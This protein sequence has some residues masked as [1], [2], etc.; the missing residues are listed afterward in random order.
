MTKDLGRFNRRELIGGYL[1]WGMFLIGTELVVS[2]AAMLMGV[3][4]EDLMTSSRLFSFYN[5]SISLVNFLALVL[6]FHRF[7]GEQFIRL[8]VRGRRVPG[9]LALGVLV[10]FAAVY[11]AS[12]LTDFLI[13]IFHVDYSNANQEAVEEVVDSVPWLGILL[14]C[15]LAPV[16]EEL[17]NR[18][19]I[20]NPLCRK[21][22]TLAFIVS[23]LVFSA[24][25]VIGS[26]FSQPVLVSVVSLI[27]YC[28]PGFALAWIYYRSE[29]IW[30]SIFL[31]MIINIIATLLMFFPVG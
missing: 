23:M 7:L 16:T 18:G 29:S 12:Y 14:T 15:L 20:F 17:L 30:C 5:L 2:L 13:A 19:L 4:Y 1:W 31:H 6:I 11:V 21:N 8:R 25:H 26:A 27:T 3:R 22:R 24:I 9:D 10:Y 28:G